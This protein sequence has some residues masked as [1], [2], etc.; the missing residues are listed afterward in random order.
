MIKGSYELAEATPGA[1]KKGKLIDA[2]NN[3]TKFA[4]NL[5]GTLY[6]KETKM[7]LTAIEEEL[8]VLDR[9]K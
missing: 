6:E 7:I 5:R 1:K 2:K 9:K 4:G 3:Y 8:A